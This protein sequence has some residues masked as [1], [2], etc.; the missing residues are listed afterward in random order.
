MKMLRKESWLLQQTNF[1]KCELLRQ[2]VGYC[3][4]RGVSEVS[5]RI[6]AAPRYIPNEL[7]IFASQ[8]HLQD[9]LP[10]CGTHRV[11]WHDVFHLKRMEKRAYLKRSQRAKCYPTARAQ[12]HTEKE[13]SQLDAADQIHRPHHLHRHL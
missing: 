7:E 12:M 2:R 5:T 11:D 6:V 8:D 3:L 13:Y 9:Q 10:A 4:H 1:S